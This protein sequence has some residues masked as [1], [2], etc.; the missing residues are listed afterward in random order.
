[1]GLKKNRRP[2]AR[3]MLPLVILAAPGFIDKAGVH[4]EQLRKTFA[5]LDAPAFFILQCPG[6]VAEDAFGR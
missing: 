5:A 3:A 1:M 6:S 4:A 2:S